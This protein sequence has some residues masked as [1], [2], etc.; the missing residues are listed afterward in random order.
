MTTLEIN[1]TEKMWI[2]IHVKRK[3]EVLRLLDKYTKVKNK[4]KFELL[5]KKFDFLIKQL[6]EELRNINQL[7]QVI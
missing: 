2:D 1:E 5:N 6:Q 4:S 3:T 7:L